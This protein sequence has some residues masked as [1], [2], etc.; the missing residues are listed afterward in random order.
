MRQKTAVFLSTVANARARVPRFVTG[1]I[2]QKDSSHPAN[3]TCTRAA[4]YAPQAFPFFRGMG[5]EPY[6]PTRLLTDVGFMILGNRGGDLSHLKYDGLGQRPVE[7]ILGGDGLVTGS[8][9]PTPGDAVIVPYYHHLDV[10]GLAA[11]V[12]NNGRP[13]QVSTTMTH[14]ILTGVPGP[15]R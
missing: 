3:I 7:T 10:G 6:F 5:A 8:G 15:A 13:E 2:V 14:F 12:Q 1:V 9:L 4:R 11:G